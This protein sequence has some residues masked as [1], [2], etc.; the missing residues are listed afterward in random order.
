MQVNVIFISRSSDLP[1]IWDYLIDHGWTSYLEYWY[2]VTPKLTLMYMQVNVT[3]SGLL[4]ILKTI[5]WMNFILGILVPCTQKTDL[6]I[7]GG[8]CYLYFKVQWFALYPEDLSFAGWTSYL[9]CCF[10]VTPKL[11]KY[12]SDFAL[13]L[14]DWLINVV[15]GILIP[16]DT[17]IERIYRSMW[18]IFM[19]QQ[20]CLWSYLMAKCH[21]RYWYHVTPRQIIL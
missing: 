3:S 14:E 12:S 15:P 20:F 2:H 13:Y 10:L 11:T 21:M 8:Q 17:K 6:N 4:C 9:G 5:C 18:P 16:C 7:Y 1:C 19:V